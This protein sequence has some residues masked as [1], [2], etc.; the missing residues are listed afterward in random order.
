[1]EYYSLKA[2]ADLLD[3]AGLLVE[4]DLKGRES[5]PVRWLTYDSRTVREGTLFICKG[6]AF[7]EEYL[8]GAAWAGAGAYVS[9]KKYE[10]GDDLPCLIVRD[11]RKAMPPLAEMF[12]NYAW[13]KLKI[14]ALGGTKGKSTSAYYMKAIVDDYMAASGGAESA[15]ISSI[16]D[17][18]GVTRTE[19]HITTPE[20]VELHEHMFNAVSSGIT[21]ME[22]E[23]SSQALKY[24]RVDNMRFDVGVFLNISEDHI[25]PIEH[26]DFEDYLSSKM[27]MFALTDH[28]VINLDADCIDRVKKEAE[29]A[30]DVHTFST[31]DPSADYYAYDIHKDGKEIVFQVKCQHF[32]SEFRLTMPGLFNVENAAAA[33]AAADILGIPESYIR[34]GLYRARSSGRME[35]FASRDGLVTAVVDYAH[36]K[37]SFEKLFGSTRQEYPDH[38][39]VAIFGCPGYKAYI[40]RRDLG[41]IA[42]SYCSK[43]YLV[44]EDPGKEPPAHISGQIAAYVREQG[45]PYEII[46]DRGAAIHKAILE[47]KRPTVILITGKGNETRQKYG[48]TYA[49]CISDVEYVKRYIKEYDE[50]PHHAYDYSGW[51]E[52]KDFVR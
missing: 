23:A 31:K 26:K 19:S 7:K 10:A 9:E 2:Y 46:E 14:T 24:D 12:F 18:D 29:A 30:G 22:M 43:V 1:M 50:S 52:E 36:N 51:T 25:S 5:Q 28:A 39:I 20:S 40:R 45:C 17:Y 33:I 37:L 13:K 49:P 32:D 3:Q 42:G 34:S 44:A 6:A 11:I 4:A 35:L 48:T 41:L 47:C 27:K 8:E 15:V 21:Y 38:D 16:D